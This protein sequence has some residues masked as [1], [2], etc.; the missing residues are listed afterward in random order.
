M[1]NSHWLKSGFAATKVIKHYYCT[2]KVASVNNLTL[3]CDYLYLFKFG[4]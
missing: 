1:F 2:F 3:F 4:F